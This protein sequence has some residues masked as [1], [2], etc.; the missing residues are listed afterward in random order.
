MP[1]NDPY[2]FEEYEDWDDD[3]RQDDCDHNDYEADILTGEATCWRCGFRWM[4][5]SEEIAAECQRIAE[6][7]EYCERDERRAKWRQVSAWFHNLI[8]AR[9]RRIRQVNDEDIPF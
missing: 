8:P 1:A 2:E 7:Q 6:Y 9:R 5:S 3:Q 4:Q